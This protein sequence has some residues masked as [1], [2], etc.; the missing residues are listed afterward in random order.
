MKLVL[1]IFLSL[2]IVT[3]FTFF[4]DVVRIPVLIRHYQEHNKNDGDD[5]TFIDFIAMHYFNQSTHT[6]ADHNSLPFNHS[7]D[8]GHVHITPAFTLPESIKVFSTI[9]SIIT[10]AIH[11]EQ[12]VLNH[13]L[14]SIFQPPKA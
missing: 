10:H 3:N 5:I 13:N 7:C 4:E 1:Y 9:P 2:Q 8:V 6:D 11:E 14:E 12:F